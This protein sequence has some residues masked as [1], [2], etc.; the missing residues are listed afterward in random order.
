MR[1][2]A[3]RCTLDRG[4]ASQAY[5]TGILTHPGILHFV[6]TK[7]PP[8]MQEVCAPKP[9]KNGVRTG[10]SVADVTVVVLVDQMSESCG[11]TGHG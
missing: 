6:R 7:Q 8:E 2:A 9:E 4:P 1:R 5:A 11:R 10:L 3:A